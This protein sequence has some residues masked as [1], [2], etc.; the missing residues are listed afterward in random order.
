MAKYQYEDLMHMA[1]YNQYYGAPSTTVTNRP[2]TSPV[3]WSNV[4]VKRKDGKED[5]SF[6]MSASPSVMAS[7]LRDGK[8]VGFLN[9]WNGTESFVIACDVI[10]HIIVRA[11]TETDIGSGASSSS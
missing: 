9:F 6:N 1:Q 5:M 2:D 4:V 8:A 11:L 7:V 10:D 3:T